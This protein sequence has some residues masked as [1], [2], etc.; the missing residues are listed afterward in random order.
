[1]EGRPLVAIE[2]KAKD[3]I[4]DTVINTFYLLKTII[5]KID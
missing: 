4:R 5:T 3:R 1:M 2:R